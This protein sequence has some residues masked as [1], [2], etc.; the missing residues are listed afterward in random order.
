MFC[1]LRI[2]IAGAP[3]RRVAFELHPETCPMT[4]RNFA[5]LCSSSATA[6]RG[7][8]GR[9]RSGCD[10]GAS[11][12]A[13]GGGGEGGPGGTEAPRTYRGTEFHRI[14][15]GFMIQGGDYENFDGTGGM[16]ADI[17][18]RGE[19]TFPDENYTIR[20]DGEGVLSMANRGKKDTNGSQFFVTLGRASHLDGKHVAFGHV[21]HGMEVLRD[22]STVDVESTG[23][24][25]EGRPVAMQ[26]VTITD[27]GLGIGS[28]RD[29]DEDENG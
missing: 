17:T 20:H 26:R 14:L 22:A 3:S 27:C 21:V 7:R 4:C 25:D 24:R 28:D 1:H 6:R 16:A 10:V 18:N 29:E 2:S 23:G 8:R 5:A 19:S 15:P 13:A 12:S 9:G 11:S